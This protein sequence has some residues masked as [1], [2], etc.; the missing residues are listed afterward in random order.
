[1]KYGS[2]V[3]SLAGHDKNDFQVVI[4]TEGDFAY[5]CN[6]KGRP[7]EK[8]KKKN[9]KHLKLLNTVLDEKCLK[10][11]KSIKV[12]LSSFLKEFA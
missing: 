4:K 2:V 12:A 7:I 5:V 1:M 9:I 10:S 3:R 11:N 6:G 8:P